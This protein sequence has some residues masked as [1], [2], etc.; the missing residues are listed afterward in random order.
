VDWY[1]KVII[2]LSV[3]EPILKYLSDGAAKKDE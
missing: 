3:M 2:D 1:D